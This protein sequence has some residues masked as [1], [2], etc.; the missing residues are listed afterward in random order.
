MVGLCSSVTI[1][2]SSDLIRSDP[3]RSYVCQTYVEE[4]FRLFYISLSIYIYLYTYISIYLYLY[5]SIYLSISLFPFSCRL[6]RPRFFFSPRIF[7]SMI[8]LSFRHAEIERSLPLSLSIVPHDRR[9]EGEGCTRVLHVVTGRPLTTY[10]YSPWEDGASFLSE[11]FPLVA[12]GFLLRC[13]QKLASK[14]FYLPLCTSTLPC[15]GQFLS[16]GTTAGDG[17]SSFTVVTSGNNENY[18]DGYHHNQQMK[19]SAG[20]AVGGGVAPTNE[21]YSAVITACG[22]A[23]Q[24]GV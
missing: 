23:G 2:Q 1:K 18:G 4:F 5:I 8:S 10:V 19:K 3:I 15:P 22:N 21:S 9:M 16:R 6:L 11:R 13:C 24:V 7:P 14:L 17:C 12:N 20:Q